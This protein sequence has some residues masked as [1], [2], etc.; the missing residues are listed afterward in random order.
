VHPAVVGEFDDYSLLIVFAAAGR[1]TFAAPLV[2]DLEV[3]RQFGFVRIGRTD[4][5]RA[6]FFAISVERKIQN[7]A[8]VAICEAARKNS[9]G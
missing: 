2:L 3:R 8:V 4:A 5:V 1:G 9:S 7:P 6:R